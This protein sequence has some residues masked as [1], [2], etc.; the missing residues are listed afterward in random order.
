MII[1]WGKMTARAGCF[2]DLL[3]L[4]LIHVQRSRQEPGCLHHSVQIDAENPETLVFYEEWLDDSAIKT[5]FKVPASNDFVRSAKVL[6]LSDNFEMKLYA[7]DL[8]TL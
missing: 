6:S 7:A 1:V 8:Y 4:S 2:E 5:H 3:K